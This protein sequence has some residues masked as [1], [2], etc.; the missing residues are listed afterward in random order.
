M[1]KLLLAV[2]GC[3]Y[4]RQEH[5]SD[6]STCSAAFFYPRC[7]DVMLMNVSLCITVFIAENCFLFFLSRRCSS[8]QRVLTCQSS[9]M[10]LRVRSKPRWFCESIP[11]KEM[12][13][14]VLVG[15]Y[16]IL[17][18]FN[19]A[20]KLY[21]IFCLCFAI[22]SFLCFTASVHVWSFDVT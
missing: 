11:H 14:L 1:R 9:G 3:K 19:N 15:L 16:V 5:F 12:C 10:T 2:Y 21:N 13:G 7:G 20:E 4:S 8:V 17:R 18:S 6:V 22:L